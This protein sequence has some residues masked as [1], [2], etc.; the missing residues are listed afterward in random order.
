[1]LYL[2]SYSGNNPPIV[3]QLELAISRRHTVQ[4]QQDAP[5]DHLLGTH[6]QPLVGLS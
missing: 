3:K 6:L 2:R 5:V 1:M 4:V